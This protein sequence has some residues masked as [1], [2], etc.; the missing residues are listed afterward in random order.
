MSDRA[1]DTSDRY[2]FGFGKVAEHYERARPHYVAAAVDWA[3]AHLGLGAGARVLDLAAG[4]GRLTG[5]LAA[6]GFDVVAVE[7]DDGM[8]AV[9]A[10]EHL[11]V[12]TLSGRAEAIPLP[13]GSVDAVTVGQGFHWF[14]TQRALAEMHRVLRPGGGFALLWNQF[15]RDDPLLGPVDE[16]LRVRRPPESRRPMWRDRYD[17]RLFGPLEERSFDERRPMSVDEVAAWV[18]SAS[19]VFTASPEEQAEVE[20]E[21][22]RLAEGHGGTVTFRTAVV[23]PVRV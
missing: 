15:N 12:E 18:A 1:A 20:R 14:D 7:P 23:V 21:V 10:R 4:T 19:P 8:R 17:E 16:L 9:L 2:R 22:R 13:D 5:A 11:G 3:V 6:R